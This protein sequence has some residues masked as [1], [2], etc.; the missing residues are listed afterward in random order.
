MDD[1]RRF[2]MDARSLANLDAALNA[3]VAVAE[4]YEGLW[5]EHV[6]IVEA[7]LNV[8][9]QWRVASLSSGASSIAGGFSSSRLIFVGLDYSAVRVALDAEGIA[10]TRELWAGLRTME[11]AAIA[12][13]NEAQS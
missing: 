11:F 13:L 7:F 3:S 6:P 5:L 10:I 12:A 4:D 1:A 9:S 2:D 8:A